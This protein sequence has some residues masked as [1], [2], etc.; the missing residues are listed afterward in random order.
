MQALA[1]TICFTAA[2]LFAALIVPLS[3]SGVAGLPAVLA[4]YAPPV[5]HA[6]ELLGGYALAVVTGYLIG[7]P[8]A[9]QLVLVCASWLTARAAWLLDPGGSWATL[10]QA[11]FALVFAA[12]LAPK[13]VGS[14]RRWRN[15]A[16]A[17][18][19]ALLAAASVALDGSFGHAPAAREAML[20]LLAALLAFMG[21]RLLAPAVATHLERAGFT[22]AA[23]VQPRLEGAVLVLLA[24]AVA[25]SAAH[26][27]RPLAGTCTLA[28][29]A[30]V[31]TRL[32]RWQVWR[33]RRRIDLVCL[34]LGHLWLGLG[35]LLFGVGLT[36]G[37]TTSAGIHLITVGG[38]GT[39]SFNVMLRA[40]L[41][42]LRRDPAGDRLVPLGTLLLAVATVAR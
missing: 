23:R 35:L 33:C 17:P 16:I 20:L 42:R 13:F 15:L 19:L 31:L 6:R 26:A 38:L 7:R 29:G 24:L 2:A 11:L 32:A 1:Q 34:A 12:S 41:Q 9:A 10:T 37:N 22:P 27:P 39:F 25:L 8:S 18:L 40:R 4:A 5:G 14:G 30:V 3:L 21:G 28:A 36:T